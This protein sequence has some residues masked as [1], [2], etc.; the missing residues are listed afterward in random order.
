[1][2]QFWPTIENVRLDSKNLKKC[3]FI[4]N[5]NSTGIIWHAFSCFWRKR[6]ENEASL[7]KKTK[8]R[9]GPKNLKKCYF[10]IGTQQG[11]FSM[12]FLVFGQKRKMK[13]C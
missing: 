7:T 4:Y 8:K 11:K 12:H 1:M 10:T 3:Y 13:Q 6:K 5:R 9:L 2:K